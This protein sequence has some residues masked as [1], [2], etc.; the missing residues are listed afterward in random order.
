MKKNLKEITI[1]TSISNGGD[2]G[3]YNKWF[4]SKEDAEIAN[5]EEFWGEP[6]VQSVETFMGSDIY[7][8]AT[9]KKDNLSHSNIIT[10][11][12]SLSNGGD[13]SCYNHFYLNESDAIRSQYDD[14]M[15]TEW[16]G[17]YYIESLQTFK[18]SETHLR[19]IKGTDYWAHLSENIWKIVEKNED[20]SEDFYYMAFEDI[21]KRENELY[22]ESLEDIVKII[23]KTKI[24]MN[25]NS[26]E[27]KSA[28]ENSKRV[29]FY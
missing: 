11:W 5:E 22:D 17:D 19:A 29:E 4:L 28:Q 1:W 3:G 15:E 12:T 14:E 10:I 25:V 24:S 21:E 26:K 18:G 13:G 20:K 2:N 8:K 6:C 7:N 27:Y 9:G 23:D 16:G